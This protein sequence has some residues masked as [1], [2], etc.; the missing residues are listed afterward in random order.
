MAKRGADG[1][2]PDV[3][4]VWAMEVGEAAKALGL[5]SLDKG[6]SDRQVEAARKKHGLNELD[7]EAS[8]PLWKLVLEQFDDTLVKVLGLQRRFL[9]QMMCS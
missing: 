4:A 5:Q 8:K 2:Q 1:D 6:L 3:P 7:K 9:P